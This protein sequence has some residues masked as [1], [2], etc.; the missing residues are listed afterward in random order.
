MNNQ[1]NPTEAQFRQS[2]ISP[3][4]R[5]ALADQ[6]EDIR[7]GVLKVANADLKPKAPRRG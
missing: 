6:P 1:P 4:I 2:H 3:E 7:R 5:T